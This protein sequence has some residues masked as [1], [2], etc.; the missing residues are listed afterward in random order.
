MSLESAIH[1]YIGAWN[2]HDPEAV[3]DALS[4]TGTYQDPTT[5]GPL[6]GDEFAASVAGLVAGFPDVRFEEVSVALTSDTSAA[7][8]W[9]MH[10]TNTGPLPGGRP[11]GGT[12]ALPGADFVDYGPDCDRLSRVVGYFDSATM[13]GQ[14]GLRAHITPADKLPTRQFGY[15]LR[16]DTGRET[17]PGALSVTWIDIDEEN[18]PTLQASTASIVMEQAANVDY[19]GSCFAVIGRR[20]YTFSAW[21]NTEAARSALRGGEHATAIR[22]TNQG[23][24]GD[25]AFGVTSIWEPAIM[26]GIFHAGRTGSTDLDELGAQWL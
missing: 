6:A 25:N 12:I 8:E 3:V 26:N 10:G 22:T 5:G 21:T 24:L 17:I 13:L 1:R 16:V 7:F 20:H 4:P 14:L 9:I 19:L 18:R 15:S 2:D 23:G 11:T